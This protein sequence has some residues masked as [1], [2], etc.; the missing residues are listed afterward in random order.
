MRILK[1]PLLN[2]ND[3]VVARQRA[4]QIAE[5]SGFERQEQT[6][7]ATA[8]SEIARN[9][10]GYGTDGSVEFAIEGTTTPQVLIIIVSD[11]G[12]GIDDLSAILEGRYQSPSGM[13]IGILG[14]RRLM[15]HCEI[16]TAR[17]QGTVVRLKKLLPRTARLI[18]G[19][20]VSQIAEKLRQRQQQDPWEEMHQ[21]NRELMAT[22]AELRTRQD[23][24]AR[25]NQELTDTN[26]G[27]VALYTEL[28]EKA[29]QI[30]RA[31][32]LKTRFLSDM[33]HEFRTPVHSIQALSRLLLDRTD[34]ELTSEQEKQVTFIK[35]AAENLGELIN[36]LLDLSK[37]EAG[38]VTV[39]PS[40]FEVGDL[41]SSLRG[42]LRPLLATAQVELHFS[43]PKHF[44]VIYSDE[45]KVSQILRNF[46]SNAIKF[47]EQGEIRVTA[48][49]TPEQ[50]A[51][52][53][54]VSD[55]GVGIAPEHQEVIF[56]EFAQL[57]N[58]L[59]RRVKGTGL[60]LPLCKRLAAL[61]GGFVDVKSSV[62]VGSTFSATIPLRYDRGT[63]SHMMSAGQVS[64]QGV[65]PRVLIIDDEEV[66]RYVL[67]QLID[68]TSWLIS[69]AATG[70]DGVR[71]AQ[72]EEPQVIF[73]D[74]N[75]PG[76]DGYGVLEQLR[77]DPLTQ[78]IPLIVCSSKLFNASEEEWLRARATTVIAKNAL[79]RETVAALLDEVRRT[80][81]R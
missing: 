69:E 7:I 39:K 55:T 44:P 16:S 71:K 50:D 36:D 30:R 74:L 25:L 81:G 14:A 24:L 10:F 31:D 3:V 6:R 23:E 32:T 78:N 11:Q 29:D 37:I 60:G 13:G 64:P 35:K 48:T 59:Q 57:D 63:D 51:V 53:F 66:S 80:I 21:Q 22:L 38:K 67:R 62:G 2:E 27:V 9:A 26:R 75:L 1:L 34:G 79:S 41:F 73:L 5:L 33:S 52:V 43:E 45:H 47:T 65:Q 70:L 18:T 61:L 76:L 77:A 17:N 28:E 56:Q 68:V 15:D 42:M 20:E 46:L 58:P 72:E 19:K 4:R 54:A 8:V 49:L 12:P 40:T